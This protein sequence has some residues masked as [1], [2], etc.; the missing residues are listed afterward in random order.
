VTITSEHVAGHK[1]VEQHAQRPPSVHR[2]RG[3]FALL[4]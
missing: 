3:E 4:P 1:P 2:G